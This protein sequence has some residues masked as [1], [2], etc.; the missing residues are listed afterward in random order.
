MHVLELVT[1][2]RSL[3]GTTGKVE[4]DLQ[5]PRLHRARCECRRC[6][7]HTITYVGYKIAGGCSNCGSYE[8]VAIECE[9]AAA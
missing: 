1:D 8:L 6:G 9:A 3:P 2:S 5:P 7:A 4:A